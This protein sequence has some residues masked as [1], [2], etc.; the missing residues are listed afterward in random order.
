MN[1]RKID[2]IDQREDLLDNEVEQAL[3]RT[4][5]ENFRVYCSLIISNYAIA[6]IDVLNYPVKREIYYIEDEHR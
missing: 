2:Y 1:T 6:G 4:I 3:E 5:E